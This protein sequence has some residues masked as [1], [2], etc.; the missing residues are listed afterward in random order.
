MKGLSVPRNEMNTESDF[1]CTYCDSPDNILSSKVNKSLE[2]LCT[3]CGR[4]GKATQ[5]DGVISTGPFFS[6]KE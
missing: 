2:L 5:D 6:Q 1:I 4:H 3:A